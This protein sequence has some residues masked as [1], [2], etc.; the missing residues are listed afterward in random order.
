[1]LLSLLTQQ[2]IAVNRYGSGPPL[3]FVNG[4]GSYKEIWNG[5]VTTITKAKFEMVTWDFRGQGES[6]GDYATSLDQL[7]DDLAALIQQLGLQRPILVGHSMGCGVI[8]NFRSRYPEIP[9][10]SLILVDQSPKM[11]NDPTWPYGFVG[12]NKRNW[13]TAY[14]KRPQ[15][16]ETLN[17]F[18]QDV[19]EGFNQAKQAHP[20]R[21]EDCLPLLKDHV[22]ADWR[23]L[24]I[25][26]KSPVYFIS[27]RKSPYY[28]PGYGKWVANQNQHTT[29]ILM[30]NCG[31]DIMAEVPDAFNHSLL[32]LLTV[33]RA[34]EDE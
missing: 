18:R 5:Q 27:A 11:I 2:T 26:E 28:R 33:L 31:H 20:F 9:I 10:K 30:A 12:L 22:Q 3:I 4:F 17:G 8:W 32:N 13:Q 16:K 14:A 21:R 15:V 7:A 29:E 34:Y 1:M 19:F 6:A 24:A 25:A 23:Q